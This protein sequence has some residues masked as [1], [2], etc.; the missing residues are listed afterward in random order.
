MAFLHALIDFI[1]HI[2]VHLDYIIQTYHT[3]TYLILFLIIFSE[4][5]IV[6][7][8]FLPG[9]SLLF[10]IGAFAARGSFNL[11]TVSITILLAAIIGD[12]VNYAIGKYIGPKIFS[13]PDS[14][15]FNKNHLFKAQAFYEKY[16]AKAI[17][18]A[19][20]IPI[21]RTFAPFVAGI[22]E[23]TYR[24]FMIYN[25]IGAMLW[26]FI[27]IPLGYFFGNLPF[28]QANFKLVMI[29]IILISL[30]PVVI[31]FLKERAELKKAR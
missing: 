29:A 7:L 9:D 17:I 31:Q 18:V 6:V 13:R 22:G 27:F 16:G 2:D 19:R 5:G 24:K 4:T 12:S 3:W 8:P 30:A 28:V 23:M 25:V 26:V 20:F 14:R 10:A 1:L 11:W 21:V 15:F